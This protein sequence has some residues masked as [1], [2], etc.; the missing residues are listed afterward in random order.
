MSVHDFAY[1]EPGPGRLLRM[2]R[3]KMC[4]GGSEVTSTH[5]RWR[6]LVADMNCDVAEL[7]PFL[8]TR[9][10]LAMRASERA[11]PYMLQVVLR[12]FDPYRAVFAG[13]IYEDTNSDESMG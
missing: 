9:Y 13:S 10:A 3:P 2:E 4:G 1:E 7:L 5:C 8:Q 6:E 12:R 11:Q